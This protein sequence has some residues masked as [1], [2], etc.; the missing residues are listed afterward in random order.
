VYV[1]FKEHLKV[2]SVLMNY[3]P[4]H[5]TYFMKKYITSAH[6]VYSGYR[7]ICGYFT[8]VKVHQ[9]PVI[10]SIP[11]NLYSNFLIMT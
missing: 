8:K 4:L 6:T 5:L 2:L 10:Y 11:R 9:E 7:I 3:K 1:V